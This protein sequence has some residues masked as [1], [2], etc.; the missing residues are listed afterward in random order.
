MLADMFEQYI[1][2]SY[3]KCRQDLVSVNTRLRYAGPIFLTDCHVCIIAVS[4]PVSV[5]TRF[6]CGMLRCGAS[7]CTA[8]YKAGLN[9]LSHVMEPIRAPLLSSHLPLQLRCPDSCDMFGRHSMTSHSV[10]TS[11]MFVVRRC[12]WLMCTR[13]CRW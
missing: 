3:K 11:S 4:K 9:D 13:E 5:S 1:Q 8:V 7:R 6:M 10:F 12:S 2:P